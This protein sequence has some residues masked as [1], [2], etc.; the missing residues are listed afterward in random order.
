MRIIRT[1]TAGRLLQLQWTYKL[2]EDDGTYLLE[3]KLEFQP[4]H[5]YA[6]AYGHLEAHKVSEEIIRQDKEWLDGEEHAYLENE[7]RSKVVRFD[8]EERRA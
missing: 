6:P 8:R 7:A 4:D 3:C 2:I 1:W 5:H